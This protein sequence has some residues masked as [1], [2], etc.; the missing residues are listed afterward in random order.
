MRCTYSCASATRVLVAAGLRPHVRHARPRGRAARAP[1]V[2]V[3]DLHAVDEHDVA[4]P[5][6]SRRSR[7]SPCPC[8]PTAWRPSR[9][10]CGPTAASRTTVGQRPVDLASR[11][12]SF[13]S[14]AAASYAGRKS[15]Q[16]NPPSLRRRRSRR[17]ALDATS[18]RFDADELR[19][20]DL[21][22][23]ARAIRSASLVTETG[24]A[25]RASGTASATSGADREEQLC[26]ARGVAGVVD[27][28]WRVS[29]SGSTTNPRSLPDARTSSPTAQH[30]RGRRHSVVAASVLANGFTASTSAREL[31]EH[32]SA[33]RSTPRRTSSRARP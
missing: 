18:M 24:S 17:R 15:G 21:A 5:R 11:S 32:G 6:P 23:V 29:P 31:R 12:R 8:V 3:D 19:P 26:R 28:R 27:R 10:R 20:D 22:S 33:S 14:V 30:V 1:T 4:V 13:T 2:R 9:A 7:A 16:M 25:T